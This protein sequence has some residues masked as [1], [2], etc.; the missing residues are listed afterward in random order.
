[1][2]GGRLITMT[3]SITILKDGIF[4]W[5]FF[6]PI[7][8]LSAVTLFPPSWQKTSCD[9]FTPTNK[10]PGFWEYSCYGMG[11]EWGPP[12]WCSEDSGSSFSL[13]LV[14]AGKL[15]ACPEN[16]NIAVCT[17]VHEETHPLIWTLWVIGEI[18][19]LVLKLLF[20][21]ASRYPIIFPE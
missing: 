11:G 2:G 3:T 8:L 13:S 6:S 19:A 4:F 7:I 10:L 1:M 17:Q 21:P 14:I 5:F 9:F 15:V 20:N 18:R 12:E 16:M